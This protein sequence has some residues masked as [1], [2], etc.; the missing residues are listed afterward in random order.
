MPSLSGVDPNVMARQ[1]AAQRL[2]VE[3]QKSAGQK[4]ASNIRFGGPAIGAV[5]G[6]IIGGYVSGGNPAG[7]L[8]GASYGS[9]IGGAA[10][11]PVAQVVGGEKDA[12]RVVA[13]QLSGADSL[14]RLYQMVKTRQAPKP[15]GPGA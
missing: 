5:V 9:S 12:G 15:G 8:K 4:A 11:E 13:S 1:A 2:A 14:D 6:G 10:A 7:V 3:G